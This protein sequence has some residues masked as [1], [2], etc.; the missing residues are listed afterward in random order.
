[1][2]KVWRVLID[3]YFQRW[4]RPDD[5]VLDVGAGLCN[6]I[7]QVRAGRKIAVDIDPA[8]AERCSPDVTFIECPCADLA[9]ADLGGKVDVAFVS[10]LLEHL[11]DSDAVLSLLT[12]L[13]GHLNPGGRLII[14][15]PN[16][17]LVGARYFDFVD[18]KTV[19]TDMS[20][21][22]AL[23]LTGYRITHMKRRFLPYTSK[24]AIPKAPWL[25]RLYLMMP[26][27]HYFMGGQTLV[28]A[29]PADETAAR[30]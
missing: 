16:F 10:N 8:V 24:S 29:T 7:N 22:E 13:R 18:H 23:E 27:A 2:A 28:V 25:V 4:V 30:A 6:F 5:A 21:I 17:A 12:A 19:L 20:L 26:I 1:M 3:H 15:Q 9:D 11:D 14:L